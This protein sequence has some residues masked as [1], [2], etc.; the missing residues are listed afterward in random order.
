[1]NKSKEIPIFT[2]DMINNYDAILFD[3]DGVIYYGSSPI[4][5]SVKIVNRIKEMKKDI[6]YVVFC[7]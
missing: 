7:Y 6:F 1:M 3:C 4:P 5:S 2:P